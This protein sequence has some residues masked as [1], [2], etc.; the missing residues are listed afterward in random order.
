MAAQGK[1]ASRT[2]ASPAQAA[3]ICFH[4]APL[5]QQQCA[6]GHSAQQRVSGPLLP[7]GPANLLLLSNTFDQHNQAGISCAGVHLLTACQR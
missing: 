4:G 2:G 1:D 5:A 6:A 7:A 3:V